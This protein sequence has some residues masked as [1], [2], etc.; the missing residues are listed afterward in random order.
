MVLQSLGLSDLFFLLYH[1]ICSALKA[2]HLYPNQVKTCFVSASASRNV[3]RHEGFVFYERLVCPLMLHD[4]CFRSRWPQFC[5]VFYTN[6]DSL[7]TAGTSHDVPLD[8]DYNTCSFESLGQGLSA[9]RTA[10]KGLIIM[11]TLSFS[12]WHSLMVNLVPYD[13]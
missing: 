13:G 7:L 9:L 11:W 10:L 6:R 4:D 3:H 1:V 2:Y 5:Q 12:V 8:K